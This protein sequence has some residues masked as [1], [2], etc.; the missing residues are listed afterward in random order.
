VQ[1][2][3]RIP[4]HDPGQLTLSSIVLAKECHPPIADT[5]NVAPDLVRLVSK[6]FEFTP[7]GGSNFHKN[8]PV[9]AF[10]EIYD[11]AANTGSTL[12]F[13]TKVTDMTTGSVVIDSGLQSVS[14]WVQPGAKK[15]AIAREIVHKDLPPGAYRIEITVTDSVGRYAVRQTADFSLD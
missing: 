2:P 14:P 4:T 9:M 10:F 12:R 3:L 8:E 5:K 15:I 1:I 11:P 13:L 7:A 6:G